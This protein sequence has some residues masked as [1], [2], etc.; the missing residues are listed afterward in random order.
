MC[1]YSVS[2]LESEGKSRKYVTT[3]LAING[4]SKD[5]IVNRES[6]KYII[7]YNQEDY[8]QLKVGDRILLYYNEQYDYFYVS[9]TLYLYKRYVVFS[10]C[11]LVFFLTYPYFKGLWS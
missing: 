4:R 6:K 1:F 7:G 10:F 2:A 5:I 11:C 3:G 8:Y 9:N